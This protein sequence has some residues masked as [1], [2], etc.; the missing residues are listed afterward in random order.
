MREKKRVVKS[1]IRPHLLFD[2]WINAI[3][4]CSLIKIISF[5]LSVSLSDV[6]RH[7]VLMYELIN[8]SKQNSST[9]SDIINDSNEASFY[10]NELM[11]S[12]KKY[13]V[14]HL[15]SFCHIMDRDFSPKESVNCIWSFVL[16]FLVVVVQ[17]CLCKWDY[18]DRGKKCSSR[19]IRMQNK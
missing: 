11:E 7:R 12:S 8:K 14:N 6:N 9:K 18:H 10:V 19:L 4:K 17:R 15:K 16:S 13:W 3:S 1:V 2:K 5:D